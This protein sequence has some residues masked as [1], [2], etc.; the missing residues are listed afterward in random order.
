MQTTHDLPAHVDR[1]LE[2]VMAAA[3]QLR[4]DG[5]RSAVLYGR[6]AAGRLR[7]TSDVNL[8]LVLTEVTPQIDDGPR[9]QLRVGQAAAGLAAMFLLEFDAFAA[10]TAYPMKSLGSIRRHRT[11][12]GSNPCEGPAFSRHACVFRL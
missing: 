8:I 2:D 11:L 10:V 6:R 1:V 9:E 12:H 4:G 7:A 5:L 3:R